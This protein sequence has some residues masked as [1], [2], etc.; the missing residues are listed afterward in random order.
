MPF[1]PIIPN[2]LE[3]SI[4][5]SKELHEFEINSYFYLEN[6]YFEKEF[7]L[8]LIFLFEYESSYL[9]SLN[10]YFNLKN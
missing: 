9:N 2:F 3:T 1:I 4:E 8:F 7:F 5:I 6:Y 10:Y